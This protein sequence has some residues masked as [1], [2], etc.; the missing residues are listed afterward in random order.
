[1]DAINNRELLSQA[2]RIALKCATKRALDLCGPL[3]ETAKYTRVNAPTLSQAASPNYSNM[4]PIDDALVIDELSGD[5]QI[6]REMARLRGFNLVP[7]TKTQRMISLLRDA[8]NV[9][10]ETGELTSQIIEAEQD[11]DLT[12]REA[13]AIDR[14]AMDVEGVIASI[15]RKV[16]SVIANVR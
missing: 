8:G 10:R 11:G 7:M 4:L 1:M 9:S 12:P 16:H 13:T 3:S 2:E 15:R 6:L 5:C 14:Q